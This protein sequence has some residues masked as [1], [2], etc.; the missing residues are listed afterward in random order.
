M[1]LNQLCP[2]PTCFDSG[3]TARAECDMVAGYGLQS[4]WSASFD[5]LPEKGRARP[6]WVFPAARQPDR[7]DLKRQKVTHGSSSAQAFLAVDHGQPGCLGKHSEAS[8]RYQMSMYC[9][10]A[11]QWCTSARLTGEEGG[12]R[13]EGWNL[14]PEVLL[15]LIAT[16]EG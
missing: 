12:P 3:M 6:T 9:C 7:V 5:E 8:D 15:I 10:L 13:E 2:Y 16:V 14:W 4:I 1:R 11:C